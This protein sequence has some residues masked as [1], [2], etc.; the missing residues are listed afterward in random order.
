MRDLLFAGRGLLVLTPVI[1]M[2]VVGVVLMRR[3]G[4]RAEARTIAAVAIAYFIYN[5][6]TGCRSAAARRGRAS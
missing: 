6:A 1:V 3:R 5:S 4:H 2:A